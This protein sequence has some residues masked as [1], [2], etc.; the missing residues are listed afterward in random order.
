ML[1]PDENA[2]M[3]IWSN[4]PRFA[5][6]GRKAPKILVFSRFFQAEIVDNQGPA[7]YDGKRF[8]LYS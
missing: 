7:L 4:N 1:F 2:A 6:N 5:Q 3:A 8:P